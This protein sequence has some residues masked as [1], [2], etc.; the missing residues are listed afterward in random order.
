MAPSPINHP[1]AALPSPR[2]CSANVPV[3]LSQRPGRLMGMHSCVGYLGYLGSSWPSG[4]VAACGTWP[5][6]DRG[7]PGFTWALWGHQGTAVPIRAAGPARQCPPG[8]RCQRWQRV[9]RCQGTSPTALQCHMGWHWGSPAPLESGQP[10]SV[11]VNPQ[12]RA[13]RGCWAV[14][15]HDLFQEWREGTE[16]PRVAPGRWACVRGRGSGWD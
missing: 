4:V 7:V 1:P 2:G 10:G 6:G 15:L 16:V 12:N 8:R 11:P 3:P 5:V 9:W 14:W 13:G